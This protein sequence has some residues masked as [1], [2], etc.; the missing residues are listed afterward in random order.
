MVQQQDYQQAVVQVHVQQ[1]IIHHQEQ[2]YA[3]YVHQEHIVLHQHHQ[4][5]QIVQLV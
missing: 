5:A 2:Q 3:Q 4:H 1:D